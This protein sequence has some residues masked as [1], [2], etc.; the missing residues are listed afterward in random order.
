MLKWT[1]NLELGL[2]TNQFHK[3]WWLFIYRRTYQDTQKMSLKCTRNT[4]KHTL[5]MSPKG[6]R[7]TIRQIKGPDKWRTSSKSKPNQLNSTWNHHGSSLHDHRSPPTKD[8]LDP[9]QPWCDRTTPIGSVWPELW[10]VDSYRLSNN[11]C[12]GI[13]VELMLMMAVWLF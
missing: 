12:M 10:S 2:I 9:A 6:R 8:G 13:M 1:S 4:S 11:S 3:F 7:L 5:D